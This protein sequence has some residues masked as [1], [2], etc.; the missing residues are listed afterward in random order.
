VCDTGSN[1]CKGYLTG[2]G[3][4]F[5]RTVATTGVG[6]FAF[7]DLTP[8]TFTLSI[9]ATGF[10]GYRETDIAIDSGEQRSVGEI[11]MQLGQVSENVIVTAEA[12]AVNLVTGERAGTLTGPQLDEIALRGRDIFDAVSLMA[13]VVDT[14]D[15]RDAPTPNSVQNIFILVK[16]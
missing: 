6:F 3:N 11:R 9:Q 5:V 12:A 13:G 15:G 2:E 1:V 8:A 14:S 7:P 16:R 10:N 4:G